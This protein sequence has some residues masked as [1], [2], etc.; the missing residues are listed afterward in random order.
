ML[1][2]EASRTQTALSFY[3][4]QFKYYLWLLKVVEASSD[5][6]NPAIA[7]SESE[8]FLS[9]LKLSHSILSGTQLPYLSVMESGRINNFKIDFMH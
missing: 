8:F 2:A 5:L 9:I 7:K 4:Q 3:L 6:H 1:A